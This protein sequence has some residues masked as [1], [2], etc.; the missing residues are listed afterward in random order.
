MESEPTFGKPSDQTTV[1]TQATVP[2]FFGATMTRDA[3]IGALI[4]ILVGIGLVIVKVVAFPTLDLNLL[5]VSVFSSIDPAIGTYVGALFAIPTSTVPTP[6]AWLQYIYSAFLV[7]PSN[8]GWFVGGLLVAIVRVQRGREEGNLKPGWDTFW[9]G[10]VAIEIP[11]LVFGVIFL[12]SSLSAGAVTL[13]GFTGSVLL[14]FLLFF[15]MP[16]FWMAMLMSLLGSLIGSVLM[17]KK[18]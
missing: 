8:L 16:M 4:S 14:F 15:L 7:F 11:F 10:A 6:L 13:Q 9:Y 2:P 3:P 17:K 1:V 12:F 5:I 18:V